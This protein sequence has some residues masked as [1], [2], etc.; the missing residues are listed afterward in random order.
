MSNATNLNEISGVRLFNE[1]LEGLLED[2]A[3]LV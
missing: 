2:E 3:V 1:L